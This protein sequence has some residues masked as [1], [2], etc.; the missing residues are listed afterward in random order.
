MNKLNLAA[1]TLTF[2]VVAAM[3][4]P[5]V[6]AQANR[7]IYCIPSPYRHDHDRGDDSDCRC[8]ERQSGQVECRHHHRGRD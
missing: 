2:G 4:A 1:A 8:R 3:P 6:G 7:P 5:P